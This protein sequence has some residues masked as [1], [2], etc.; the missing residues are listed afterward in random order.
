MLNSFKQCPSSREY[1][2]KFFYVRS[3]EALKESYLYASKL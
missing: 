3:N 2:T 1:D